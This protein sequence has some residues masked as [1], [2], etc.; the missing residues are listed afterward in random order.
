MNVTVENAGKA[1]HR[2]AIASCKFMQPKNHFRDTM[3]PVIGRQTSHWSGQLA[4]NHSQKQKDYVFEHWLDPTLNV[5]LSRRQVENFYKSIPARVSQETVDVVASKR[6][7]SAP[8][9]C[10]EARTKTFL[11]RDPCVCSC[12]RQQDVFG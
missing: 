10:F 7:A 12:Y 5:C 3:L 2:F 8:T 4:I 1:K 9:N 6:F 11:K